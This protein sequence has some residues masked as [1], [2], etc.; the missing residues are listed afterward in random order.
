MKVQVE[1]AI[2]HLF[3]TVLGKQAVLLIGLDN[4][5]QVR[6][7]EPSP[8]DPGLCHVSLV[9]K[10]LPSQGGW[11]PGKKTHLNLLL[12]GVLLAAEDEQSREVVG[13]HQ[14]ELAR[15]VWQGCQ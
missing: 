4:V 7:K 6:S 5:A 11:F 12:T 15:V 3:A 9:S 2:D 13:L 14:R 10:S 1:Q 8:L